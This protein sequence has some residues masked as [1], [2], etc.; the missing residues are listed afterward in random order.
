MR[1]TVPG[2]DKEDLVAQAG[3][4][5]IPL[6]LNNKFESLAE[7]DGTDMKSLFVRYKDGSR[8]LTN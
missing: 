2:E 8:I 5:E 1:D 4:Q 6:T 3:K 7:D